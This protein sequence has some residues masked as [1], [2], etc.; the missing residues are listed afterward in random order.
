MSQS[1]GH[2]RGAKID[3][4]APV[5]SDFWDQFVRDWGIAKYLGNLYSQYR[6]AMGIRELAVRLSNYMEMSR[7]EE[8]KT[9]ELMEHIDKLP[10][11]VNWLDSWLYE[12]IEVAQG[13]RG[14]LHRRKIGFFHLRR[15]TVMPIGYEMR[16]ILEGFTIPMPN[17]EYADYRSYALHG[18]VV[19]GKRTGGV[20]NICNTIEAHFH[21]I[22]RIQQTKPFVFEQESI[23]I[24]DED[25]IPADPTKPIEE[26]AKERIR[27]QIERLKTTIEDDV[28]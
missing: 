7:D 24:G 18:E 5:S 13:R 2:V 15:Q 16:V 20:L 28:E 11:L 26:V 10:E 25:D 3:A 1:D 19:D 4:T 23:D 17:A 6:W 14:K 22:I 21:H 9:E 8:E 12:C 27:E